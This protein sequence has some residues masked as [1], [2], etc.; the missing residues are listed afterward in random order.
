MKRK[1]RT[2]AEI[3]KLPFDA[4]ITKREAADWM[5]MS[6]FTV[7]RLIEQKLLRAVQ[8]QKQWRTTKTWIE[9]Y[10]RIHANVLAVVPDK[11]RV[12]S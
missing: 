1:S 6:L 5:R 7:D 11:K 9:E 2:V 10:A 4:Y 8:F 3:D 12:A